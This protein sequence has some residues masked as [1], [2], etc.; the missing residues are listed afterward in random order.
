[1]NVDR[2]YSKALDMWGEE[3]QFGMLHEEMGELIVAIN[4]V[5][6][7]KGGIA[8]VIEELADVEIMLEQIAYIFGIDEEEL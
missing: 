6:R 8:S 4:K 7:G 1:M 3:L 2:I 5:R